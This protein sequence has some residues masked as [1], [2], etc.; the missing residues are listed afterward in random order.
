MEGKK[1]LS[2]MTIEELW[3]LFPIELR[4]YD[5]TWEKQ[6]GGE[7]GS[8]RELLRDFS[9]RISHIGSTAIPEIMAK[10]IVDI[11]VEIPKDADMDRLIEVLEQHDYICM[12]RSMSRL[13][14]NKGYTPEGYAPEVF[15]IHVVRAGDNDEIRFRDY[16]RLHPDEAKRYELLK[17]DLLQRYGSDRDAY[18]AGKSGFVARIIALAKGDTALPR[19]LAA[20]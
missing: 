16:L 2:Q 9:P 14:F 7:M 8:L 19:H 15:H 4:P 18:T 12:S 6:A 1:P 5:Q 17:L 11:L 10:P 3:E 13:S 20:D